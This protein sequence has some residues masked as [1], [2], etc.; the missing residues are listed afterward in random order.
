MKKTH[1]Q[2]TEESN[3]IHKNKYKYIEEYKTAN[4]PIK[5]ECPI[6]GIFLQRPSAHITQKQG[7]PVC[8]LSNRDYPL[9]KTTEKF[10]E[11]SKAKWGDK[12]DYNL[13]NYV[14]KITKITYSCP[15]HGK[16]SQ[17]PKLHLKSGC[18][19][20]NGRGIGRHTT[21]TFINI[22]EKIHDCKYDYS[23]VVLNKITDYIKIICREHGE[24]EQRANNHIHLRNGC[25]QCDFEKTS[26]RAERELLEYIR[27]IYFG[28]I[29]PNDRDVLSGKEV[30]IYLPDIGLGFE[31]HGMWWHLETVVGKKYHLDK[32]NR[33]LKSGIKLLQIYEYEWENKKEIVK[34]KIRCLLGLGEKIMARKTEIRQLGVYEKD[35]F[36][37]KTHIQGKD[38]SSIGYGLFFEDSLVAC[39][40][41]GKSRFNKNYDY[42]LI[43]YSSGLGKNVVGGASKLLNHFRK[44]NVGSIISY[45][46]RR[47]SN[48]KLYE[49]LGFKFDGFSEPSFSY[50]EINKKRI[51]NRMNFQKKNLVNMP[52]Y[53]ED[54]TEYEIMKLNGFDRIWDAGQYRFILERNNSIK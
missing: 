10:I 33:S 53:S 18:Q 20:C 37:D 9:R 4:I 16:I 46:D 43:R 29:R 6:H 44:N 48:G 3:L 54:L 13:T 36:L 34:S 42:E 15:V 27:S 26:S 1:K 32:A 23:L 21:E 50:F 2:F 14:N 19:Y 38:G 17:Y 39:M 47:W 30:D 11:Q 24:F 40:T 25:P 22:A 12:Y 49:R 8:G 45:A 31:Y 52:F 41:F 28:E 7:C 5:I 51:Y 35:E